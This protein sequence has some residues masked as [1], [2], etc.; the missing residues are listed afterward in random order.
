EAEAQ[1]QADAQRSRR[2]RR[3]PWVMLTIV[4]LLLAAAAVAGLFL[5]QALQVRDDL[6]AAKNR[7]SQVMPL[8]KD[9]DTAG[10]ERLS[11]QVLKYTSSADETV[12]GP[13]WEFASAVPWVGAN[14]TAVS[15]TTRATHIL[16]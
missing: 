10:V 3:W 6:Q 15:E 13:L 7:V 4:L 14:V 5:I 16:V 11:A 8:I 9:G 12:N 1:A 2:R